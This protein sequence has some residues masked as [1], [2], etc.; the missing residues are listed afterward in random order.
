MPTVSRPVCLSRSMKVPSGARPASGPT[1]SVARAAPVGGAPRLSLVPPPRP[2]WLPAA[3]TGAVWLRLGLHGAEL[4]GVELCTVGGGPVVERA[5]AL[6]GAPIGSLAWGPGLPCRA[7]RPRVLDAGDGPAAAG[8]VDGMVVAGDTVLGWLALGVDR[9]SARRCW[10]RAAA[11]LASEPRPQGGGGALLLCRDGRV[12]WG[13]PGA[14][15]WLAQPG[16]HRDLLEVLRGGPGQTRW[17][18]GAA[19][20]V[21]WGT[22]ADGP[23]PLV[24]IR[25]PGPVPLPPVAALTPS[26]YEV[27]SF[28]AHAATAAEIARAVGRSVQTVRSHLKSVYQRLGVANRVELAGSFGAWGGPS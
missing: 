15:Q 12:V 24:H 19:V 18:D 1:R 28:A 16:R 3:A 20:D 7:G 25:P 2:G 10:S 23:C 26:Q 22:G 9:G 27:A 13:S 8:W 4:C 21:D 17:V 5:G 14:R 11:T 6:L